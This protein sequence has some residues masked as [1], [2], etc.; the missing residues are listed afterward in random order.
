MK[1]RA[2]LFILLTLVGLSSVVAQE[3]PYAWKLLAPLGLRENAELDTLPQNYYRRAIPSLVSDAYATTGNIG[4][5][6]LN[7]IFHQRE[8]MSDFFFQDG[9]SHYIPSH[10]KQR[11]YNT[12]IPWTQ[13]AYNS[14]GGK[15]TATDHLKAIFSGNINAKAQVGA[16]IDFLYSKGCY[17]YQGTK[18]LNWGVNG[19]YLGDRYEM[20]AYFNQYN[21]L[22][23]ENGGITDM[24]YITD[25]AVLQGGVTSIDSKSIP[26]NLSAAHTR[27]WGRELY[28]NNRYKVGYWHEERDAE[29]DSVTSRTY[30]PVTS[31]IYTFKWDNAEHRF[32]DKNASETA[33]FFDNTY[34]N[35]TITDDHSSYWTIN[36]TVGVSLLEGFHKYAKFGLSA[37]ITHQVRRYT[38]PQDTLNRADYETLTPF[39][40]GIGTIRR[41]TTQQLAW[42]G[43]QLTKQRGSLLTYE[44]TAELGILGPAAGEVKIDG[45]VGTRFRF[46]GDSLSI[47]AFG[48]FKN[49][50][51]PFL[52]QQYISNHFMWKNDFGMSRTLT[53]GGRVDFNRSGTHFRASVT[54]LQNH[55]YF[56]ANGMPTQCGAS[57]QVLSLSL[58]QDIKAGIFHWD[59]SITYQ[60]TTRDDVVPL[61]TLTVYSNA[62]LLFRIATLKAQLGVDCDYYTRYYAPGYQPALASFVNQREMKVGNYPF[63]SAYLNMKLSKV[64]FYVMY[65]HFNEGLFGGDNYFSMPY[66]PLNQARFQFGLC[67]DFAN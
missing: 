3:P 4:A 56:A 25:P 5:E 38:Q 19:S 47:R 23:K 6:G 63:C 20:Q 58:Q 55:I 67:I 41:R 29:T 46:L 14:A 39:P 60:T 44:A 30:V 64:R 33:R 61:P 37:Y 15:T 16:D 36:N 21:L 26:T 53:L 1:N 31:F 12:R 66:Y 49:T 17:E 34:L 7:M 35:P 52:M 50:S 62:Y 13:L 65:S 54:N 8:A 27:V 11:F 18:D 57:V 45:N 24:L 42:V 10:N 51:A 43:A 40:E 2:I 22:N 32:I 28:V 48:E 59:N 9:L